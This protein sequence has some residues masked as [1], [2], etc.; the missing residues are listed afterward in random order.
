LM[1]AEKGTEGFRDDE[2]EEKVWPGE[3]LLQ[4]VMQPLL[5]FMLLALG[6]VP[7]ATGMLDPVVLA[8]A[9]ALREALSIVSALAVLASAED[10][11]GRGRQRGRALQ[12][13][14]GKGG[15]DI[16]EGGHGRHPCM[17]EW[18]RSSASACPVWVRCK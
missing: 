5:G 2:G 4:V 16:V 6:T 18:R 13:L 1:G 15:A 9:V 12:G 14:W 17:R 3:L 10:L 8:T 11:A 7:V